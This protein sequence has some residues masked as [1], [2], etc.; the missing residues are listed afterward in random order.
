MATSAKFKLP[1][2][3]AECADQL[4]ST[5]EQRLAMQKDVDELQAQETALRE[6]LISTLPKSNASGIAGKLVR[7]SIV[8]KIVGKVAD[9]D[10]LHAYIMKTQKKNPGVW[11][12]MNKAVNQ[13]TLKELWESGTAVP[14]V[15]Q[16]SVPTVS[17][18][19]L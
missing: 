17:V 8:N 2:T 10:K 13:A 1:K 3:L 9:W 19:K 11:G 16:L 12:L 4:Y 7:V 5:R 15:D 14:G 6:H 18:N